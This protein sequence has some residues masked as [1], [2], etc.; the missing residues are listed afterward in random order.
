MRPVTALSCLGCF[1]PNKQVSLQCKVKLTSTGEY[2]LFQPRFSKSYTVNIDPPMSRFY[3]ADFKKT[4]FGI[5]VAVKQHNMVIAKK[6]FRQA[7]RMTWYNMELTCSDQ[8]PIDYPVKPINLTC[9]TTLSSPP[10][11]TII[12]LSDSHSFQAGNHTISLQKAHHTVRLSIDGQVNKQVIATIQNDW[13]PEVALAV[14]KKVS[15]RLVYADCRSL[16]RQDETKWSYLHLKCRY[17]SGSKEHHTEFDVTWKRE[18]AVS[19][20]I[21]LTLDTGKLISSV[22]SNEH[23]SVMEHPVVA[24]KVRPFHLV[25]QYEELWCE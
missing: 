2:K 5:S 25:A 21:R 1:S 14:L 13:W 4:R 9:E 19:R 17:K 12:T 11:R 15:N 10:K 6:V 20:S 24:N 23:Q 8:I 22:Y 18:Y 3:T 16:R 7:I